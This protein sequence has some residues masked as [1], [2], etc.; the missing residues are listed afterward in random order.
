MIANVAPPYFQY[1]HYAKVSGEWESYF[2]P[3]HNL[4]N[5]GLLSFLNCPV[6]QSAL[7][8]C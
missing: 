6:G 7:Q 3:I 4:L 5:S 2:A 1:G 8:G